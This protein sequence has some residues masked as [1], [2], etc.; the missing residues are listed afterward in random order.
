MRVKA[1][2]YGVDGFHNRST[3]SFA[4]SAPKNIRND[5]IAENTRI[6]CYR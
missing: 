2:K 1:I 3:D 4:C 5:S 6:C